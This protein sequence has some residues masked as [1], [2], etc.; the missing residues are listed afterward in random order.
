MELIERDLPLVSLQAIF[1]KV[2]E[3]EGHCIFIDGEAGMGKTSLVKAFINKVKNRCNVYQGICDSLFVP[4]PLAPIFDIMVQLRHALPETKFRVED[5]TQLFTELFHTLKNQEETCLIVFEDIHWAD[6]ATLDFIKFLARRITQLRCLFLLTYRD[7][8]ISFDHA[9]S[10]LTG[11]LYANSFTRLHLVPLSRC[12]V[13][14]L[15]I[16]KGYKG[17]DV[18]TISGGNPFYVNEI[19]ASYSTGVPDNIKDSVLSS[20]NRLDEA[21]KDLWR[22][23]AVL[24][25]GF[26]ITYLEKMQP[27]YSASANYC[28]DQKILIAKDGLI[29]FKHELF[30]RTIEN[31]LSPIL[32]IELNKRILE[33]FRE[34]FEKNGEIERIIHHAKAANENEIVVHYAPLA[35]EQAA[36]LGAHIQASKLYLTAIEYYQDDDSSTLISFYELYAYECYLTNQV[37]EAIIYTGKLMHLLQSSHEIERR[38]NCLRLLSRLWWL[39][40]NK[41]KAD[42]YANEAVDL[43]MAEPISSAKAMSF[44]NMSQLKMLSDEHDE[45]IYWGEKAIEMAKE[46]GD[47]QILCH[48]LNNVGTS[49]ARIQST[50]GQ[51]NELLEQSLHIAIENSFHEHA[52]RAFT[53][54]GSCALVMKDYELAKNTLEAGIQYCE[55]RDLDP[56]KS[57][58][59]AE[60]AKLHFELGN[61]D[62]A[63]QTSEFLLHVNSEHRLTKT[64]SLVIVSR[65][66]MRKG[67]DDILP[68]LREAESIAVAIMDLQSLLPVLVAFLEYEWITGKMFV[69]HKLLD[70]VINMVQQRGNVFENSEFAFWLFKARNQ[71][72]RINEMHV[73]FELENA[74]TILKATTFWKD[75]SCPY[76]QA[77]L[78]FELNDIEKRKALEIIDRLEATAVFEKL[79]FLMRTCGIKKLPKGIRKTTKSNAAHL[80]QRELDILEQLKEGLQNKEIGQRLFISP[81]TVEHHISSILF[82]LDVNSRAKA[83]QQAFRLALLN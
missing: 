81:K 78:L 43:F 49:L 6:E 9:I 27:A 62:L 68:L 75:L 56:W 54:L 1:Q 48:A 46:L 37:K 7:N 15:S 38:G 67:E 35:A 25:T 39:D 24:P 57:F 20:F 14:K 42:A 64:E 74:V 32:R 59:S 82:K 76:E 10:N 16:D 19:L 30:R 22:L 17:E 40:G 79:K 47:D 12:A 58:M 53:N 71:K 60:K 2:D 73:G 18:Y 34:S 65:I 36:K 66:K 61:W 83:V 11:Q 4:R 70:A 44:S 29:S 31:S 77:I 41:K 69:E 28:L 52:A 3:G 33:L 21:T 51:G 13:E 5:R 72:I 26:E 63:R 50:R 80:T 23:L 55:A 45:C 8:E